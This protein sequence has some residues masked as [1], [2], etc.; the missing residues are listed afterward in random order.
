MAEQAWHKARLIPTWGT[1]RAEDRRATSA[2]FA[3]RRAECA[4]PISAYVGNADH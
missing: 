4:V 3:L 2:L 1:S